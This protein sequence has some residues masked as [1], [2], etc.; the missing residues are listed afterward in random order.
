M[1]LLTGRGGGSPDAVPGLQRSL[2]GS[3]VSQWI[4]RFSTELTAEAAANGTSLIENARVNPTHARA[5]IF[6]FSLHG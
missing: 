5:D 2:M 1:R 6:S 3:N 4:T